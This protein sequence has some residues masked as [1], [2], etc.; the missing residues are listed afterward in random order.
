MATGTSLIE[1]EPTHA[2]M[3]ADH[4]NWLSEHATWHDDLR[5]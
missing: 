1:H 3:H 2:T 5:N 4:R